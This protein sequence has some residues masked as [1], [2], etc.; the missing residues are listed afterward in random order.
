MAPSSRARPK[1]ARWLAIGA[2]LAWGLVELLALL[3]SR[4]Q[5]RRPRA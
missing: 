5:A 4:H 2:A 3:R 1:A